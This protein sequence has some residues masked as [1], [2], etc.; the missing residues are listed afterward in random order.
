[1]NNSKPIF[2]VVLFIVKVLSYAVV[3]PHLLISR[4]LE[5]RFIDFH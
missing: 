1:M 2:C 3:L 5:N 4:Q